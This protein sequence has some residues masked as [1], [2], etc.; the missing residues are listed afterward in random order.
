MWRRLGFILFRHIRR[1]FERIYTI[2]RMLDVLKQSYHHYFL[3]ASLRPRHFPVP[4]HMF[5]PLGIPVP[6]R[7]ITPCNVNGSLTMHDYAVILQTADFS[8][9]SYKYRLGASR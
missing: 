6:G 2:R 3:V 9:I 7:N 8:I 1:Y 5:L 4:L